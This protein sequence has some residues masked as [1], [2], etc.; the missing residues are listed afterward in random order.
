MELQLRESYC[1]SYIISSLGEESAKLRA[2][3]VDNFENPASAHSRLI[4]IN[5]I[6]I[7]D[8]HPLLWCWGL[9]PESYT[10]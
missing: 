8:D 7:G 10:Y 5:L 9:K 2:W 4:V 3:K 6:D 1:G